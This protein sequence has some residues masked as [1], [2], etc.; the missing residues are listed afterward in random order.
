M[1]IAHSS[2]E[3]ITSQPPSTSQRPTNARL[4]SDELAVLEKMGEDTV[5]VNLDI[6]LRPVTWLAL[7]KY[8]TK[9]DCSLSESLEHGLEESEAVGDC[10]NIR[11]AKR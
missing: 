1:T 2:E 9:H 6:T 8:S 5:T 10:I 4:S 7:Q 11:Q 3:K